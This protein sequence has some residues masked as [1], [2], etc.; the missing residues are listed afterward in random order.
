M[1]RLLT[2]ACAV[3]ALAIPSAALAQHTGHGG[4]GGHGGPH[5]GS[6]GGG[7]S[8]SFRGGGGHFGSHFS[9]GPISHFSGARLG[10]WRG[11]HW[12]HGGFGGRFGWWWWADGFW[13]LYDSPVYPYPGYVA[14]YY[15]PQ[16]GGSWYYCDNPAGYYPYVRSCMGPWRAVAPTPPGGPGYSEGSPPPA[17]AQAA[18]QGAPP[19]QDGDAQDSG[20]Q[21]DGGPQQD[22]GP[23]Q[24]PQDDQQA[25]SSPQP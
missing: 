12:F 8:P 5:G 2:A 20:P 25:P 16:A 6:H 18:P 1:N 4:G 23:Q 9:A 11:G 10:V 7:F 24:Q 3:A 14:T 22:S 19:P 17:D 15:V 21:Q 13:Y